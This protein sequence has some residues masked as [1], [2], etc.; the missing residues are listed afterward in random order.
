MDLLV[1][2]SSR[3]LFPTSWQEDGTKERGYVFVGWYLYIYDKPEAKIIKSVFLSKPASLSLKTKME[4]EN[5]SLA[6]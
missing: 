2:A 5:A 1:A 6:V 3:V 4:S